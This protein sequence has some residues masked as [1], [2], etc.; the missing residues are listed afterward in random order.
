MKT[1][2]SITTKTTANHQ[3]NAT[4]TNQTPFHTTLSIFGEVF[5]HYA[6]PRQTHEEARTYEQLVL[7]FAQTL[8][9]KKKP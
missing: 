6:S 5:R 8:E 9:N 2:P 7:E 1:Q 3:P 4:T